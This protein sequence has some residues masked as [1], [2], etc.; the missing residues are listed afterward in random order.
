MKSFRLFTAWSLLRYG[1]IALLCGAVWAEL[2]QA[3]ES[4]ETLRVRRLPP[5]TTSVRSHAD[6]P[7]T[8]PTAT[9]RLAASWPDRQSLPAAF[10]P[11]RNANKVGSGIQLTSAVQGGMLTTD[12]S[13]RARRLPPLTS[14]LYRMDQLKKRP[15]SPAHIVSELADGKVRDGDAR[16]LV[17]SSTVSHRAVYLGLP[18]LA[19]TTAGELENDDVGRSTLRPPGLLPR[20]IPSPAARQP[21]H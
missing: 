13:L 9:N 2:A 17:G 5:L 21:A 15:S 1:A 20:S 12:S 10:V 14:V 3:Q 11:Q 18:P 4:D 19:A 8:S 6:T 16:V 7:R